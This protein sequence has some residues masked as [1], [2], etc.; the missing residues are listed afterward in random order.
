MTDQIFEPDLNF[1][2]VVGGA[3]RFHCRNISEIEN[4]DNVDKETRKVD[5][6]SVNIF[7]K[8]LFIE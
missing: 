4:A 5:L 2:K 3:D 8:V 1:Y 6:N 7:Q